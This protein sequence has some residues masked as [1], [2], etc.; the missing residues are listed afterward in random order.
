MTTTVTNNDGGEDG[1]ADFSVHVRDAADA[2]VAG[3]PQPGNPGGTTY[4]LAPG[5]F[6][7]TADGPNLY[8]L[9][10]GGACSATGAVALGESQT[11]T[12]TITADD[13]APRAGREVGAIPAGGTVR[14]KKPGG[15]FQR[16][17]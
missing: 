11:A 7:V 1:P 12:C 10:I 5:S 3:S 17:P 14:I 13:R 8:A 4:T 2:D 16:P 15:R 9:T 6:T